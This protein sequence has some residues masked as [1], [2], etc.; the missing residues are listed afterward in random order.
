MR[1]SQEQEIE[2]R[3]KIDLIFAYGTPAIT[4]IVPI[5]VP[6]GAVRDDVYTLVKSGIF[7][8]SE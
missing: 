2:S 1:I 5:I 7:S 8:I 6:D 3:E 4:H